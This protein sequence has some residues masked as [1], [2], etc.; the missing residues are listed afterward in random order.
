MPSTPS[1]TLPSSDATTSG[2]CVPPGQRLKVSH[3][4]SGSGCSRLIPGDGT[5][6]LAEPLVGEHPVRVGADRGHD[7]LK[8]RIG[9]AT[10]EL[11]QALAGPRPHHPLSSS[12]QPS[13]RSELRTR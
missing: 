9:E 12:P 11:L 4:Q 5:Q 10:E 2:S 6:G 1:S 8:R 13:L 3:L 7:V